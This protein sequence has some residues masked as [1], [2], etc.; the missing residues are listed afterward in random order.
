MHIFFS[1]SRDIFF[2]GRGLD[3]AASL[4]GSLKLKE[5][6]YIHSEA[7][8]AGELK[9]GTISLIED[10]IL[11]IGIAT[12]PEL[13]EKMISNMVEVKSRGAYILGITS[14]GSYSMEDTADYTIYVP[15]TMECFMPSLVVVP[16]QLL[17]YYVSLGKGLDVDK[18][19]SLAKSVTVE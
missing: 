10:G 15:K 12:Q 1:H 16:L 7:Y 3:Y 6:S 14:Y 11:V 4:E 5:I 17:A 19:R 8:A 2:I 13:F 9:H 18:P